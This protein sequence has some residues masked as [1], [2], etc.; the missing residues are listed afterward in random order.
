MVTYHCTTPVFFPGVWSSWSALVCWWGIIKEQSWNECRQMPGLGMKHN[1][2]GGKRLVINFLTKEIE[3]CWLIMQGSL[4]FAFCFSCVQLTDG[5]GI[6]TRNDKAS[7][8][9]N[10]SFRLYSGISTI[11]WWQGHEESV[12]KIWVTAWYIS[13]QTN[14]SGNVIAKAMHEVRRLCTKALFFK[15]VGLN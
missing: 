2:N 5:V 6:L 8:F 14:G 12:K 11:C 1:K 4:Q 7:L 10:W 15:D 13:R 3:L 9:C